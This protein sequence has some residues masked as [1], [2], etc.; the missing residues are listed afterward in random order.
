MSAPDIYKSLVHQILLENH[1]AR[2]SDKVLWDRV[3]KTRFPEIAKMPFEKAL[4]VDYLPSYESITRCRRRWQEKDPEC[5]SDIQ[6]A[7]GRAE[8]ELRYREE[9]SR[10]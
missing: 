2:N 9:Y 6:I 1:D 3:I 7:R 8:Q 4:M 5:M 10:G